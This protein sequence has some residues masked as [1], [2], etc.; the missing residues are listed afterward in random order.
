MNARLCMPAVVLLAALLLT[1]SCMGGGS[2]RLPE[3]GER[4][5]FGQ[6]VE[7]TYTQDEQETRLR[8][9]V[10]GAREPDP[11]EFA[12]MFETLSRDGRVGCPVTW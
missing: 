9:T 4:V 3:E 12:A 6:P 1:T 10:L 11:Q 2:D 7:L 5:P 8:V